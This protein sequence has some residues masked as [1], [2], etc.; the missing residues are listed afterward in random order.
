LEDHRLSIEQKARAVGR[1]RVQQLIDERDQALTKALRG[2]VPL[3]IP[4]CVGNDVNLQHADRPME[5]L[6]G[7]GGVGGVS[8]PRAA[9]SWEARQREGPRAVARGPVTRSWKPDVR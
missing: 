1:R 2:L 7:G 4:V 5:G 6:G 8:L 9:G 3:A